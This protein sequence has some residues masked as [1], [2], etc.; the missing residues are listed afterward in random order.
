MRKL[1][2]YFA[3]VAPHSFGH[4]ALVEVCKDSCV[5][6]WKC[7]IGRVAQLV[8]AYVSLKIF[9]INPALWIFM[10]DPEAV[11]ARHKTEQKALTSQITSLKKSVTKGDKAKRKEVLAQVQKLEEELKERH[12]R[13]LS[14]IHDAPI[15]DNDTRTEASGSTTESTPMPVIQSLNLDE[16]M[17]RGEG[18]G[19]KPKVNRQKA[20]MVCPVH[21]ADPGEK[22]RRVGRATT[23]CSGGGKCD[24]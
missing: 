11:L 18:N 9:K 1:L 14:Q 4:C 19:T 13:E 21:D 10:E 12:R 3:T 23:R 22:S 8:S 17:P 5:V 24:A 6:A 16:A 20:R 7:S 2:H 15:K